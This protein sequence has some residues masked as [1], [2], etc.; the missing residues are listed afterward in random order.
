VF[1]FGARANGRSVLES[2][3][4]TAVSR[5]D[6]IQL[7]TGPGDRRQ[8]APIR[9]IAT[10][11]LYDRATRTLFSPT[12]HPCLARAPTALDRYRRR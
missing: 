10:R 5:A 4:V 12:A 6:T 9:L 7:E 11:W 3:K 1:D 2:M 8:Q